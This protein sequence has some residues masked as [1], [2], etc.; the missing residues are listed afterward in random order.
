MVRRN[1][2]FQLDLLKEVGDVACIVLC[3][4][5]SSSSQKLFLTGLFIFSILCLPGCTQLAS[6]RATRNYETISAE[7]NRNTRRARHL[8]D[9]AI[10]HIQNNNWDKATAALQS[11]LAADVNFGPAHNNLGRV[12]FAQCKYYL[13]AWELQHAINEMPSHA[14]PISN[15]GLVYETV[16][17]NMEALEQYELAYS[18]APTQAEY[19]GNLARIRLV[20]DDKDPTVVELLRE[21]VSYDTRPYWTYWAR[22]QLAFREPSNQDQLKDDYYYSEENEYQYESNLPQQAEPLPAPA[23]IPEWMDS[24]LEPPVKAVPIE[25]ETQLER[26]PVSQVAMWRFPSAEPRSTVSAIPTYIPITQN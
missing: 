18:M 15:L 10:R 1:R 5:S 17:R 12:Y 26:S 20:I 21:L 19:I 6:K 3:C 23:P 13:A 8:N 11:A 16:G 14:E 24:Q 4:L 22:E 7:P 25:Y 9:K 2:Y